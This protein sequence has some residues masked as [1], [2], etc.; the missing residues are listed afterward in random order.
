M[1]VNVLG[2]NY[3]IEIKKYDEEPLFAEKN[4]DGYCDS[5]EKKIVVCDMKT[6]PEWTDA[7]DLRISVCNN[8]ILRHEIV[9]AFLKESGLDSSSSK[10]SGGWATHE[11]MVDWIALQGVK[12]YKAWAEVGAI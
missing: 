1:T 4:I 5:F 7:T 11:E 9:H 6:H 3:T 2:T 8:E 12:I 10:F